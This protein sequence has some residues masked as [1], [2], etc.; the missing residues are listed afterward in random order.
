MSSLNIS[1]LTLFPQL[2]DQYFSESIFGAAQESGILQIDSVDF[3]KF[4][5]DK[6]NSVDG[7]P[8]GGGPGMVLSPQPIIDC[9]DETKPP[10]PVIYLSP[11]GET[12]NQKLAEELV[13]LG[14]FS[15]LC[16]RY[17]GLDQRVRDTVVDREIS[18]GNFVLAGGE[19]A[20]ISII[21]ATARL[22]PGVVGN[23]S[24]PVDE[25]FANDLIEYPQYTRPAEFRG[26]SVP[27][28]LRSGNHELVDK[29]R[30]AKSLAI[31]SRLRPDLI[32]QRGGL[33]PSEAEL[34]ADF[35]L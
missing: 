4:S 19:A 18:I 29:W 17:E 24:S 27:E 8:F 22:V 6:H 15:L 23:E 2:I 7:M 1:V 34:L 13:D 11:A 26:L 32:E 9:I 30:L 35:E 5:D 10:K 12:F 3:R 31:T 25:S 21:E 16:G 33:T 14:E 28:V 20:A